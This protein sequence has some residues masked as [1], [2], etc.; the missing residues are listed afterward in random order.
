MTNAPDT[1]D[2]IADWYAELLR[3]GSPLNEF[4]RDQLLALLPAR[5]TGLRI[6]DL[7]CGEGLVTRALAERG[8][9]VDGIDLSARL[10]EHAQAAE[11]SQP[12]GAAYAVDDGQTLRTVPDASRHWVVACLSLNNL[13]DLPAALTAVS[14]VLRPGGHLA[15][16][17]PHPCFE[18]PHSAWTGPPARRL[19]GDYATEG[20]WRAADPHGVR[21]AGNH[22]RTLSSYFTA[23]LTHGFTPEAVCEPLP[24]P[25]VLARQPQR[26]GLPPFLLVTSSLAREA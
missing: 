15:F 17:V 12:L 10:I 22:H 20:F 8:A 19:V 23:L 18:A 16:A 5:L 11:R 26:A 13:P 9:D 2:S 1:W 25:A 3:T 4:A 21:R 7:G 14:R 24:G 6:L